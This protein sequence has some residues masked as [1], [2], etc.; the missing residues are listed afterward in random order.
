[1]IDTKTIVEIEKLLK[2]EKIVNTKLLSNS[3]NINCYKLLLSDNKEYVVKYYE[4][5]NLEFNAIYAEA[6]ILAFL[7][8]L[9]EIRFPNVIEFTNEYLVMSYIEN[10]NIQPEETKNDF[11]ES[12]VSI[13]NNNNDKYG[14]E[15]DSQIWGLKQD[16]EYNKSWIN[17]FSEKR[18]YYIYNLINK[19]NSMN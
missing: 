14:F 8:N 4:N 2:N 10:N 6:R 19:T 7:N 15:Y 17:F 13:H 1:M 11:L 5:K 9:K 18:L 3:F 12:I 16:N